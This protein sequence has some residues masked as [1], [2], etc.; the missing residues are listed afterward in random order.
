MIQQHCL[1]LINQYQPRVLA[2]ETLTARKNVSTVINVAAARG[3]VL[4]TAAAASLLVVEVT[5][6]QVKQALTGNGAAN[7]SQVQRMV[8]RILKLQLPITS[9]DAADALAVALAV[10]PQLRRL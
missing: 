4:A 5:P 1:H 6:N 9:D 3:V 2:I 8:Q 10:Q 7:K